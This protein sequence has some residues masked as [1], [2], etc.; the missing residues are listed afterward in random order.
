MPVFDSSPACLPGFRFWLPGPVQQPGRPL[1]A[2]EVSR[3][4]RAQRAPRFSTCVWLLGYAGPDE[5]SRW[6][7]RQCGLPVG[8]T[9]SM[10]LSTLHPAPRGTRRKTRGQDGSL[11]L[12]RGALSSPTTH[13]FIPTLA[14]PRGRGLVTKT[15]FLQPLT[16]PRPQ[17]SAIWPAA[18]H[19]RE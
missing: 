13:R 18:G 10:P 4:S 9:R 2:G 16:E 12:S 15:A 8:S 1:D 19:E 14:L 6:R 5:N 7:S 17:G 3:F 11:L